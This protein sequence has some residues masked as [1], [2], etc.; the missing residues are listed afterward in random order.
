MYCWKVSIE[1]S[2]N[3]IF[4]EPKRDG[5]TCCKL[6][7]WGRIDDGS[8]A[9][10]LQEVGVPIMDLNTCANNHA[11]TCLED[12]AKDNNINCGIVTNDTFC[13]GADGRDSCFVSY[14]ALACTVNMIFNAA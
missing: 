2:Y 8:N 4:P 12:K 11:L 14:Q 3:N 13:A 10:E 5:E 1:H 9:V 6:A 7:G